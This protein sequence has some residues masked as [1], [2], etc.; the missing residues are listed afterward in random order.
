MITLCIDQINKTKLKLFFLRRRNNIFSN[1]N[2]IV[3]GSRNRVSI[4]IRT[5]QTEEDRTDKLKSKL[6]KIGR[7]FDTVKGGIYNPS[8]SCYMYTLIQA[9]NNVTCFREEVLKIKSDIV[10]NIT[11]NTMKE[12]FVAL[13]Q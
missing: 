1:K 6:L 10:Q 4:P 11:L 2:K 9:L 5:P 12:I 3:G 7:Y 13:Q 8:Y